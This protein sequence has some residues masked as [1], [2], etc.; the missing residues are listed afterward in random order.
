MPH[1]TMHLPGRESLVQGWIVS[2]E[3]TSGTRRAHPPI[4]AHRL[5]Q[6]RYMPRN[7]LSSECRLSQSHSCSMSSR[8]DHLCR[9]N[10]PLFTSVPLIPSRLNLPV[11]W[12]FHSLLL[13][14]C[15]KVFFCSNA[16]ALWSPNSLLPTGNWFIMKP[17]DTLERSTRIRGEGRAHVSHHLLLLCP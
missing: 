10:Q 9:D 4:K 16:G 15:W 8:Y 3:S 13:L 12:V 6:Y 1:S 11:S 7:T 2:L 14:N 5:S 17:N